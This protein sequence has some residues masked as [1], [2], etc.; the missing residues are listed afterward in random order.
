[1]AT[2][3]HLVRGRE[4]FRRRAWSDARAELEAADEESPLDVEDLERLAVAD[5]LVGRQQECE[6]VWARAH[7]KALRA[8]DPRR[9]ARCAFW[10]G[11]TLASRGDHAPARGWFARAE[12]TLDQGGS[13]CDECVE[14][15]YLLLPEALGQVVG[16]DEAAARETFRRATEIGERFDEPDLATYG[17]HG[18]GRALIRMGE[19]EA[20]VALLDEAMVAVTAGEISPL[21]A[22][23]VYCSVIEAC[24]ETFDLRRAH[25]WTAALTR[26]C[27]EQP[28]LTAYRGQ[29]LTRRSEILQLHGE[30]HDALDEARRAGEQLSRPPGRAAAGAAFYQQAEIHRLRGRFGEAEEA[31]RE[32]SE[33]GRNP[34]PGLALLRLAQGEAEV[35]AAAMRRVVDE[36]RSRR[37]RSR[38]LGAHV[39]VMVAVDDL[40]AAREAADEL[41]ELA[42]AL[43][44]PLLRAS[45]AAARGTVLLEEGEPK[46]ALRELRKAW[47]TW[48]DLDVPHEAARVQVLAARACRALGDADT[49]SLELAAARRTFERLGAEPA[50]HEVDALISRPADAGTANL[51]SREL[52]VLR[53][54]ATGRTNRAIGQ[55]LFISEKTVAR[56]V[57]NIFRKLGVSSRTAATAYAYEHDLI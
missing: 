35:A 12:R 11:F 34:H 50:L 45:A 46:E 39:E 20:G 10:L 40:E 36:A 54:V 13:E 44:V 4:A 42:D 31:Y 1:M 33:W 29:C 21:V 26:W 7:K 32:A 23:D 56:H 27:E 5:Y 18:Q 55:E 22:G 3:T 19:I 9:S 25:E 51:T 49:A 2:E 30:W 41:A 38:V 24:H 6:E 15:G 57:S 47:E 14:R 48:Q 8:D 53:Q 17:R 37:R 43:D 52:E 16:G 28:D